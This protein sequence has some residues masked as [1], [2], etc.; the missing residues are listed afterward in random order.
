MTLR[1]PP[2][3]RKVSAAQL[4]NSSPMQQQQADRAA[5]RAD[6]AAQLAD[7][8][9][10]YAICHGILRY[11][12]ENVGHLP[13]TLL[14]YS[15]PR[16][17]YEQGQQATLLFN[18]VYHRA[19][20]QREFL[21]RELAEARKAD[22]FVDQLFQAWPKPAPAK[23]ILYMTRNDF[24]PSA[25]GDT[26]VARQVEVNLIAASLGCMSERVTGLIR[27]LYQGDEILRGVPDN[28]PGRHLAR[29]MA[30]AFKRSA[31]P[32]SVILFVTPPGEANAFDQRALQTYLQVEHDIP[33]RRT[34]LEELGKEGKV[35]NG[36]LKFGGHTVGLV[37]FRAGYSPD[38]YPTPECWRA[39][40]IIEESEAISVP[41]CATQLVNTKKMQEVLTQRDKL[42]QFTTP[43][44]A[45]T[46][47]NAQVPMSGLDGEISWRG[48][49]GR[50]DQIAIDHCDQWVLK[51]FREGGGNNYFG[52]ELI[53]HLGSLTREQRGAYV[54][55]E[56][57][58][59]R[60]FRG[61][62]LRQDQV[63]DTPCVTEM[64]HYTACLMEPGNPEP[65]QN[66]LL[67]Y[68][69]RSKDAQTTEAFVLGDHSYLDVAALSDEP[70]PLPVDED[71]P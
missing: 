25:E 57:I 27:Y 12:G 63:L 41:S 43:E 20:Q 29:S 34:H 9:R 37:Y 64:G 45:T 18:D 44:I 19:A 31:R 55:M 1:Q 11:R 21:E 16:P 5:Q 15:C 8:A 49:T 54:L 67:G 62:R 3:S 32:G 7:E 47:L 68:L 58:H 28:T 53:S 59:Q 66:E 30:N 24:M 50:A 23:P 38:H 46:L 14:P 36:Q 13:L 33:V 48:I 56:A 26:S 70:Q 35:E 52:Q 65:I 6:H 69:L 39:R 51:P 4:P 17:F 60:P 10:E 22:D 2:A 61:V 42:E 40:R 71:V